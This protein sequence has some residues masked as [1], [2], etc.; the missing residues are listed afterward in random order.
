MDFL[1]RSRT[2]AAD[3][4][5]G[6]RRI[7]HEEDALRRCGLS[8]S[9]LDAGD[10]ERAR[11]AMGAL[12]QRA[13]E[14]PSAAGLGERAAAEV[15]LQ[16]GRLTGAIGGARR[17]GGAEE[18]AKD[19]FTEAAVLFERLGDA[20]KVAESRA[21][22]GLCYWREG[23]YEE[24]RAV[25]RSALDGLAGSGGEQR[26]ATLVR[27][28][29]VEFSARR[30]DSVLRLL[31]QAA[32]LV[33]ASTSDYLKGCF[34]N[35]RA[36]TF[37]ALAD[38]G[39]DDE[40][41]DRALVE[42]AAASYHFE[43]AGHTRYHAHTENN[44]AVLFNNIGRRE[45][46]HR[47]LA[48]ARSLFA[49]LKD[50]AS[51]AQ[52][53]DTLAR[54]LTAEGRH[55]EAVRAASAAVRGLGEGDR[56]ALL[57]EALTTLGVA[58]ARAGDEEEARRSL[59]LAAETAAAAGDRAG[60]GAAALALAEELHA[61]MTSAEVC[62]TYARAYDLLA[63][64]RDAA[65]LARLSACARR[66][67]GSLSSPRADGAGHGSVDERWAGFSLKKEVLRYE[68]ELIS[69]ALREADGVVSRAAK[70]LGFRHH[71]T[72]VALLN[73]RHKGLLHARTPIVPRRRSLLRTR[74]AR[75]PNDRRGD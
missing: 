75:R 27:L 63:G 49:A 23:A 58:Q 64:S 59:T 52:C 19:L 35:H 37:R 18:T 31:E 34:H 41:R 13:G 53:D 43:Q 7:S 20:E 56:R 32:P 6:D 25:L 72:F 57:A 8:K 14:R 22:L 28:A 30:Y 24:A 29:V 16:S 44:L 48:R 33:E 5:A 21:E 54:V 66:A 1:E 15:L 50:T 73:N 47:H 11:E 60:A 71:Q 74:D 3:A 69:R 12:W 45:E 36:V 51:V 61:H 67:V 17:V 10:Y 39:G 38:V 62:E 55:E 46:A 26:G 40:M 9:Y 2:G 4:A 70:L 68:S 65:T 42:Y